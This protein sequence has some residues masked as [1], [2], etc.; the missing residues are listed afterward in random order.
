VA[1]AAT[2]LMVPFERYRLANGMT[3]I[4]HEDHRTPQVAVNLWYGVG[5]GDERPGRT[6]FAHL[7]EH[8]MF[9]GSKNAPEGSFDRI[10]EAEGGNNNATTSMDRTNYFEEGPAHLLE[11][12]LWLEA[13]RMATLGPTLT[14]DQLNRQR[15]VVRNERRQSY[16]NAPYGRAELLIQPA[17]YPKGHPYNWP[18]I[19]AHADLVAASL[20]DVRGFFARHYT[21]ANASLVIAGDF[22]PPDAR[23]LVERYFGWMGGQAT[24]ERRPTTHDNEFRPTTDY[25]RASSGNVTTRAPLGAPSPRRIKVSDRVAL[26]R[27]TMVWHSPALFAPGDAACDLLAS[28]LAEGKSSRLYRDLVY[29]RQ[30]AQEVEVRQESHRLTSLFRIDVTCS[31]GRS[32]AELERAVDAHLATLRARAPSAREVDRARRRIEADFVR[33]LEPLAQRA[34]LLNHYQFYRRDPGA[35]QFDLDRYR[36]LTPADLRQTAAAVLRPEKRL[37]LT[38]APGAVASESEKAGVLTPQPPSL[39]GRRSLETADPVMM[40][41]EYMSQPPRLPAP[42]PVRLPVVRSFRLRNGLEVALV[43]KHEL[44]LVSMR[45]MVRAGGGADPNGLDGLASLTAEMLDEGAGGRT[46]LALGEQLDQLAADLDTEALYE[47]SDV[48]LSL[49]KAA[50]KPGLTLFA[51][52]LLRPRFAP[53]EFQRVRRER[54]A[55]LAQRRTDPE[56]VAGLVFRRAVYGDRHPYGRPLEGYPAT[57]R[58]LSPQAVR[59]FHQRHFRPQNAILVVAGDLTLTELRPLVEHAFGG[60]RPTPAAAGAAR[61]TGPATTLSSRVPSHS[62]LVLVPFPGAP[63]S[64]LRIGHPGPSR[65]TPAFTALEA[66]N[67][68]FGGT[69]TSRL[70]LNLRERHGYTYGAGS[71]FVWQRGPGP[72]RIGASVFRDRTTEAVS[73]TLREWRRIREEAVTEE[74]LRKAKAT[75]REQTVRDLATNDAIVGLLSRLR[76]LALPLDEPARQLSRLG[77]LTAADLRS[78]ARTYLHPD[79]ATVVIVGDPS[80]A[81]ALAPLRLGPPELRDTEGGRAVPRR[82]ASKQSTKRK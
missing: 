42:R 4:L 43:E 55:D 64:A 70:N 19:G 7:F 50:L 37:T 74:E 32:P 71:G 79:R 56:E 36:R 5:S 54:L 47:T 46:A 12:F 57:V 8:L 18:V 62:S 41:P 52:V 48:D 53:S 27:L 78:A 59:Q 10:M 24:S 69:F 3:V 68:I 9:M 63:Q 21:P 44:P 76:A 34:D 16:E 14:L 61:A 51:D 60:W 65:S 40:L 11:T 1:Q 81:R 2:A 49:L 58:R 20:E 80:V 17:M 38:V 29:R 30:I 45:M 28:I 26:P 6:G 25:G 66:L 13:D 82:S 35:L 22:E 73:E 67:T 33:H 23:R 15:D 77:S 39:K 75:L 31:P 72:F